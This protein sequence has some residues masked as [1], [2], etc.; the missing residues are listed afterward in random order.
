[1]FYAHDAPSAVI[2]EQAIQTNI[3]RLYIASRI[4][5]VPR[6]EPE[7]V[8]PMVV[9]DSMV[10]AREARQSAERTAEQFLEG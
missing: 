7:N 1:M 6:K 2:R 5:A 4:A 3:K 10:A 8:D 9:V